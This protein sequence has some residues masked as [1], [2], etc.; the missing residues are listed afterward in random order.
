MK[1]SI[2]QIALDFGRLGLHVLHTHCAEISAENDL[3]QKCWLVVSCFIHA[4][5]IETSTYN[6]Q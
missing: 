6:S 2:F 1:E 4:F 5:S 3:L